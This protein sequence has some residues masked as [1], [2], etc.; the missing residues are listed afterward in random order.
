MFGHEFT[1]PPRILFQFRPNPGLS[2]SSNAATKAASA[3]REMLIPCAAN[4]ATRS[5]FKVTLTVFR[6]AVIKAPA[7][8]NL[9]VDRLV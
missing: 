5:A 9:R 7:W 2:A 8:R 1:Y 3:T 4:R 6:L